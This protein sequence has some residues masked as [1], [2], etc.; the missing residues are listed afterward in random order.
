MTVVSGWLGCFNVQ[1]RR[2]TKWKTKCVRS[3]S[4]AVIFVEARC[5]SMLSPSRCL[6]QPG[7]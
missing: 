6:C 5:W 7:W 3:V 4:I 1:G 2:K